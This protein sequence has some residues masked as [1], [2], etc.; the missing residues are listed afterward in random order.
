MKRLKN[1]YYKKNK[2]SELGHYFEVCNINKEYV[3]TVLSW[4]TVLS[5]N[6]YLIINE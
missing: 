5:Y 6:Q 4:D 2:D 1:C 3:A